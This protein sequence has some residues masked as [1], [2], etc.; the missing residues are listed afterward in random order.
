MFAVK[1][2]RLLGAPERPAKLLQ[3]KRNAPVLFMRSVS[4]DENGR[5][6]DYYSSYVRSD[7][8]TISADAEARNEA[9]GR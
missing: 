3:L 7:V 9:G 2:E 4:R 8:V 5:P 6:F 1:I